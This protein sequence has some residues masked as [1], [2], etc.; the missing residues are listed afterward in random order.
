MTSKMSSLS[1][2]SFEYLSLLSRRR[3]AG[4]IGTA[5]AFQLVHE[6][7]REDSASVSGDVIPVVFESCGHFRHADVRS[8]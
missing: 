5:E 6:A 7:R 2:A 4:I 8:A 1:G 3:R